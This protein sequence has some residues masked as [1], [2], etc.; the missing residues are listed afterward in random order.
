MDK[1]PTLFKRNPEDMSLVIP[2]FNGEALWLPLHQGPVAA[3]VKKDGTNIRVTINRES[4]VPVFVEKRRNPSK[5]EKHRA[6]SQGLP[7]PEPHYVGA[8]PQDPSDKHIFA[9]VEATDFSSWPE[10]KFSCEALGPKIQGG[11]ESD[12]PMLYAFSLEPQVITDPPEIVFYSIGRWLENHHVEG[13]V[14]HELFG[15]KRLTKIKRRDFGL[16]WP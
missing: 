8:D 3:T 14:W 5:K 16:P 10:G 12:E 6:R 4:P 7:V 13:I 2:E 11:V 1:I 15:Q 9:A